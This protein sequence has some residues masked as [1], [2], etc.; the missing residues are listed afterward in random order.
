MIKIL[1]IL[2][3]ILGA[4][5]LLAYYFINRRFNSFIDSNEFIDPIR[6]ERYNIALQFLP[7]LFVLFE[8]IDIF[9]AINLYGD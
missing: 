5:S 4:C 2:F 8:T 3:F 1:T 6:M 7:V 9:L